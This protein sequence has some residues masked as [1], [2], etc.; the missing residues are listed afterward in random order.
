LTVAGDYVGAV[1]PYPASLDQTIELSF[2]DEPDDLT[3]EYGGVSETD[4]C[5]DFEVVFIYI[6]GNMNKD[7]LYTWGITLDPD[8]AD[9]GEAFREWL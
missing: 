7:V 2:P 1:H 5:S 3:V 9:F 8:E 4:L 6:S